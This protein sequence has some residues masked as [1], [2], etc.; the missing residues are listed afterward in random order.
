M[1]AEIS[2]LLKDE[3]MLR[4][5]IM[6]TGDTLVVTVLPKSGEVKAPEWNS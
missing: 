2:N 3:E 4:I 6:K 1:F 5:N